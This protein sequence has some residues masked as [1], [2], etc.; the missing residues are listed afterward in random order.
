QGSIVLVGQVTFQ[1][2]AVLGEVSHLVAQSLEPLPHGFLHRVAQVRQRCGAYVWSV[3]GGHRFLGAR[4]GCTG[5]M[6]MR[7]R[8]GTE[9]PGPLRCCTDRERE[10]ALLV[11]L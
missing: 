8:Q 4:K 9:I 3:K 10:C 11:L 7:Q 6:T 1:F 2:A 5:A